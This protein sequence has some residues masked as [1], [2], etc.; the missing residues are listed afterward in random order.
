MAL[1]ID[2]TLDRKLTC[3]FRN[4]MSNLGNFQQKLEIL[5]TGTLM[6][7]FYPK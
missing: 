1:K 7:S 6:G 3:V 2:A 5:K 4:D